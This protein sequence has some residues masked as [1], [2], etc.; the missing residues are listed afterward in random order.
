MGEQYATADQNGAFVFKSVPPGSYRAY[1]VENATIL[2]LNNPQVLE[3]LSGKG[4]DVEVKENDKKQIQ[5]KIISADD[6]HQIL[7]KL[8][9]DQ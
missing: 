4:T 9:I 5:L 6:F 1:P 8:G 3:A 2:T 7:A